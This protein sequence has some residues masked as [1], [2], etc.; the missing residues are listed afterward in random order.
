MW[1][2]EVNEKSIIRWNGFGD[3]GIHRSNGSQMDPASQTIV[4][5][6]IFY[7]TITVYAVTNMKGDAVDL[8]FDH[9]ATQVTGIIKGDFL[10]TGGSTIGLGTLDNTAGTATFCYSPDTCT[11]T[12]VSGEW[13][14]GGT[15][16]MSL[17]NVEIRN[18]DNELI[19]ANISDDRVT[20]LSPPTTATPTSTRTSKPDVSEKVIV[21]FD[22]TEEN[23]TDIN[24]NTSS[25]QS[26]KENRSNIYPA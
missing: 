11:W 22:T 17:T 16:D 13:A 9:G 21:V 8:N 12:P 4:A 25:L 6:E 26:E 24:I 10:K 15:F 18:V 3:D 2:G 20:I 7:A 1:E 14:H 5:G 23:T 19:P